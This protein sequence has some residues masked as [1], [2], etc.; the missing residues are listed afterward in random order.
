[1]N[2][3]G[4]LVILVYLAG[5]PQLNEQLQQILAHYSMFLAVLNGFLDNLQHGQA[6]WIFETYSE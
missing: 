2:A 6:N 3:K 1:L 4:L 5:I